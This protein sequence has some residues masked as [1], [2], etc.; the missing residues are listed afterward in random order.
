MSSSIQSRGAAHHRT[1]RR[2]S[3]RSRAARFRSLTA[4]NRHSRRR[5]ARLSRPRRRHKNR[6]RGGDELPAVQFERRQPR[7]EPELRDCRPRRPARDLAAGPADSG[8]GRPARDWLMHTS[9]PRATGSCPNSGPPR[10]PA[11]AARVCSLH[12]GGQ[13]GGIFQQLHGP[14]EALFSAW[15][16]VRRGRVA[17]AANSGTTGRRREHEAQPGEQLR[18]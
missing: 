6:S 9:N 4:L 15:I 17:L 7:Q 3:R 13:R 16:F 18:V 11:P 2:N 8:P 14:R 5:G 1:R 10:F 12:S